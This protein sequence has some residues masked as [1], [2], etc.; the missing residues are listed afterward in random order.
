MNSAQI[1]ENEAGEP[2]EA[3]TE[4]AEANEA[5]TASDIKEVA[6]EEDSNSDLDEN[7]ICTCPCCCCCLCSCIK[8]I[9]R[10]HSASKRG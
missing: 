4:A 3:S 7:L 2:V 10:I 1:V 5:K 8:S 6:L 9:S